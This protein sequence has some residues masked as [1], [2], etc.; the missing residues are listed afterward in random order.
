M[1]STHYVGYHGDYDMVSVYRPTLV[2]ELRQNITLAGQGT[3]YQA[4]H[5][6]ESP[7]M[8]GLLMP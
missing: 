3:Y 1:D 2:R 4:K 8:S 5:N 6:M 7:Q